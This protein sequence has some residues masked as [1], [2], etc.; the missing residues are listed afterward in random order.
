MS[1]NKDI[2]LR[3]R[4]RDY[5]RKTF[6]QITT[7]VADLTKAQD[8]QIAASKRGEVGLRALEKSYND[9]ESA[10]QGLLKQSSLIKQF[11][12][13]KA[14]AE[15]AAEGVK[16]AREAQLEY[17]KSLV[18]LEKITKRQE[19]KVV[20]LSNAVARAEGRFQKAGDRVEATGAK[21]KRA[22]LDTADLAG[23]QDKLRA[24]VDKVN[25]A[26]AKQDTAVDGH[27]DAMKRL[28]EAN[29]LKAESDAKLAADTKLE[30]ALKAQRL[31]MAAVA[32]E[33][34]AASKDYKT[35]GVGARTL[36]RNVTDTASAI[37]KLIDPAG[38][39]RKTLKGLEGQVDG[40]SDKLDNAKKPV[41]GL[42]DVMRGLRDNQRVI[43][44]MAELSDKFRHQTTVVRAARTEFKSAQR[45]VRDAAEAIRSAEAP[46][47]ALT[48][49]LQAAQNRLRS[50]SGEFRRQADA[51]RV[52]QRALR[53]AGIQTNALADAD[54]RLADAATKTAGAVDR[55]TESFKRHGA[56]A[57][58][59]GRN[60]GIF[61]SNG[62]T[63]LGMVQ[64]LR[65]EVLA[66]ATTY[67]GLQGAINLAN[68]AVDAYK[69]RQKVMTQ[70]TVATKGD[71]AQAAKEWDYL[72][73]MT[74]A[75]G[76]KMEDAAQS[77]GKF[78]VSS[79]QIGLS[80]DEARFI[81]ENIA[82]SGRVM[83]L[84][85]DDLRGVFLALEQMMSKGQVY[86]EELRG[87]LAERLPG[88]IA[89]FAAGNEMTVQE[90]TKAL[91]DGAVK[92]DAVINFARQMG[93]TSEV[94]AAQ[95]ANSVE[96]AEAR[97]ANAMLNFNLGL[98]DSGFI[99]AYTSLIERLTEFLNSDEGT[100]AAEQLGVAFIKVAESIGWAVENMETLKTIL[101]WFAGYKLAKMVFGIGRSVATAYRELKKF[102]GGFGAAGKAAE[103]AG[104]SGGV[105]LRSLKLLLRFIPLV[106]TALLAWDVGK[107]MYDN[108]TS[109][110][111]FVDK[112]ISEGGIMIDW[113]IGALKTLG[114]A[115]EGEFGMIKDMWAD[116]NSN[117]IKT[118][119]S[120]DKRPAPF[121]NKDEVD[122]KDGKDGKDSKKPAFKPTEDPGT[123]ATARDRDIASLEKSIEKAEKAA[124]KR[125]MASRQAEQRK[126]LSGRLDLIDKEFAGQRAQAQAVDG[127]EGADLQAR[128][129]KVIRERKVAEERKFNAEQATSRRSEA[130]KRVS[131]AKDVAN[132]L[133]RIE[134]DLA[135]KVVKIDPL[136]TP[137]ERVAAAVNA[138]GNAYTKV[139][140]D[141]ERLGG[142]DGAAARAKLDAL[143]AQTK[144]LERQKATLAEIEL[145]TKN[146]A[147]LQAMADAKAAQVRAE[148]KTGEVGVSDGYAQLRAINEERIR[149][150]QEATA[151][152][153]KFAEANKA[154]MDPLAYEQL[155]AN[156]K[157]VQADMTGVTSATNIAATTMLNGLGGAGDMALD[158]LHGSMVDLINNTGSL[159]DV[160]A[161]L[162]QATAQF[163]SQLL[164]D[165][166][167][168]I[169]K[170][171]ILN[172][173]SSYGGGGAG[174]SVASAVLHAGGTV[175]SS[176]T[177]RSRSISPSMFNGAQKYHTGGLP[178]LA[179]S[180]VPAILEKGEEVLAKNDPRNIMNGGGVDAGGAQEQQGVKFVL[181]DD[182]AGL[183][184]AMMSAQ[185][186]KIIVQGLKRN[187]S[188]V[189]QM[190]NK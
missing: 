5:S 18:G 55:A 147:N 109:F 6:E 138:A 46:T 40:L 68:G 85:S 84:S 172:A 159:G 106:G 167:K 189:R 52:T 78:A 182:R 23:Q 83:K 101:M 132:Q 39:A 51:A 171:T 26:L 158:S 91:E 134:A 73:Q 153:L 160:F 126:S 139:Y 63:T 4:A 49:K 175:G 12:S 17:G 124:A 133:E 103:A 75:Y 98:A 110:S 155:T 66:L 72:T 31:A 115:A 120:F 123:G 140:K 181:V 183:E 86:A 64:R 180:E 21:M 44:S 61:E 69:L 15:Q 149:G 90:L 188:T 186:D 117:V 30:N 168:A 148:M 41:E 1:D 77:Y 57:K 53:D 67:A 112:F 79:T 35:L 122:G 131:L 19:S 43:S 163:F 169:V 162:G 34:V 129:D 108:S 62:R 135:N 82:K 111:Y 150:L 36:T 93:K 179:S 161:S 58:T 97:L 190:I 29:R 70:L 177:S 156:L 45:D 37:H 71:V 38:A 152:A 104:K 27:A 92:A 25:A 32:D 99:D 81:F 125:D 54:R 7:A 94:G 114:L 142:A 100:A 102:T 47:A 127:K 24:G 56:S 2:E 165:I 116:I 74:D 176:S 60:L 107:I 173:I 143:V 89:Q 145:A 118:R 128:L 141:I 88:A 136:A 113:A 130:D 3:I 9:L 164:L 59:A 50:A 28:A 154:A 87:Q 185:G 10:G 174:G 16:T 178:G 14:A 105:F 76:I 48:Q 170:Q 121:S 80:L 22:G 144:E 8:A 119:A 151:E 11:E 20:S 95:A 65:G 187:L 166:A 137:A 146:V 157:T 96:A 184:Q 42:N 33:A 13:Q